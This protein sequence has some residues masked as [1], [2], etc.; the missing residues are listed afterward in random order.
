M[1]KLKKVIYGLKQSPRAWFD[2]FSH[3]ASSVG[4]KRSQVD[5][6][7]FIRHSSADVVILVVYVDDILLT[8]SD[9]HGVEEVRKYVAKYFVTKNLGRPR[10]FLG[11]EIAYGKDGASLSQ[12]KYPLDLLKEVGLLGCKP[13]DTPTIPQ[14]DLDVKDSPDFDDILRYRQLCGKLIYLIVTIHDIA[15]AIRVVS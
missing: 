9:T 8:S 10:Y 2:K 7:V 14:Q 4:F 3:I 1:C 6:F 11:I 5:H 15:F 12:R 13:T